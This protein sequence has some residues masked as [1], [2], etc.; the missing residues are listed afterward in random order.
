MPIKAQELECLEGRIGLITLD[1]PASLNALS[2][3]MIDSAQQTLERW[4]D[5]DRIALVILQGA[6]DRTGHLVERRALHP[7]GVAVLFS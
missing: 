3:D 5:D 6:G 4:T 1:S 7:L 2:G